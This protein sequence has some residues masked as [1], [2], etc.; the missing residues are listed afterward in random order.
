MSPFEIVILIL[1]LL[2][3]GQVFKGIVEKITI[4]SFLVLTIFTLML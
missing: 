3:M 4:Y 1:F 2:L